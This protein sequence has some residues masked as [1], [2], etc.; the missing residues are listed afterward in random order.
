MRESHNIQPKLTEPWLDAPHA[1]ELKVISDLLDSDPMLAT[2][3]AQ[4]IS[5]C[6]GRGRKGITG[7][8]VLRALILK[9]MNG[10]SYDE[11]AFHLSDS[12]TYQTFC[13]FGFT[14]VPKRST[15]AAN[16]NRV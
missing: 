15:L 8:Q 4:D 5:R 13:R 2:R 10:Y 11:L 7:E 6:H 9:Q 1:K 14:D 3:V 16:I 12:R